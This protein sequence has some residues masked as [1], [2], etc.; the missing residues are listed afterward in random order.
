MESSGAVVGT[1]GAKK[2]GQ[3]TFS[4]HPG[5]FLRRASNNGSCLVD[6]WE[7]EGG[8]EKSE[9]RMAIADGKSER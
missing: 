7:G 8:G 9:W 3:A 5:P 2:P 1:G 4:G 6:P